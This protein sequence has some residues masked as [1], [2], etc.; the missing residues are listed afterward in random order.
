[1]LKM[2]E[3]KLSKKLPILFVSFSLI[4]SAILSG[5]GYS[6]FQNALISDTTEFFAAIASEREK[7]IK[8]WKRAWKIKAVETMN[9]H[10]QDLFDGLL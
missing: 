5:F 3:M 7:A 1:M 6:K 2:F 4:L 10:W 9:P 8:N